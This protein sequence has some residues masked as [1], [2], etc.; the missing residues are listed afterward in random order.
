MSKFKGKKKEVI[1]EIEDDL[2]VNPEYV[3][4][5]TE[6]LDDG[7]SVDSIMSDYSNLGNDQEDDLKPYLNSIA[8]EDLKS[9]SDNTY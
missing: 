8:P 4:D 6:R 7:Q 5:A 1:D 3:K 2:D 9:S